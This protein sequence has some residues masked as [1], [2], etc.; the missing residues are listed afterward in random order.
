VWFPD[1]VTST[2]RIAI[3]PRQLASE[4]ITAAVARGG[5]GV[6]IV[7]VALDI[8]VV[9]EVL[10]QRGLASALP[11]PLAAL[12]AMLVLLLVVGRSA[13]ARDRF[14]YIVGAVLCSGVFAVA[15]LSAD[16]SLNVDAIYMVNR[17]AVALI[18][19]SPVVM[20]PVIGLLWSSIGLVLSIGV[21]IVSCL[22]AGVPIASGWGPYTSWAVY[23][24]A[25][26][27]LT[28]VRANQASAVPDLGR[29]E[30]E[31]K[32]MALE[33]QFEQRAAAVIHD[34]VLSDLTAVMNLTGQ[35][36]DRARD[37]FRADVA[38]LKNPSWLR[39]P[40]TDVSAAGSTDARDAKLRN[41]AVA[42]SSEMQWRGLS[43]DVTGSNDD[44]VAL[45]S[46]ATSAVLDALRA[47][48]ENVL[49]H[50]GERSAQ[51]VVG[52]SESELTYMVIDHGVGFDP[53]AVPSTRLGLRTSVI[54]RIE[55]HGGS[56]RVWSQ[57]GSGTSVLISMPTNTGDERGTGVDDEL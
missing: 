53:S 4:V 32:R 13:T 49:A 27:V 17:P 12:V 14:I 3:L 23:A 34:T 57:P 22:V 54:G 50:S 48:L 30:Q 37:R 6:A 15:L 41:G 33:S 24:I 46:A 10:L 40:E 42:L 36:D 7:L 39:T 20:R 28:L 43:V 9:I 45:S 56:V 8:P 18:L 19:L 26:L 29:L 31:T 11:I 35:L 47:C 52:G 51:L 38:T 44:V 55:A 25:Y 2:P 21:L 5:W 1:L 16:P